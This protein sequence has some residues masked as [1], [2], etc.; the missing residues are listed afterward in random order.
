MTMAYDVEAGRARRFLFAGGLASV[1]HW[2][3][4]AAL[5]GAGAGAHLATALGALAGAFF[6]YLLQFQFTYRART[7]HRRAVPAYL[8]TCVAAWSLNSLFFWLF[9]RIADRPLPAQL[10]ATS[11]VAAVNYLIYTRWVFYESR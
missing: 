10:L 11:G 2:S 1:L 8:L 5:M 3:V 7:S 6:N 9:F 4:M